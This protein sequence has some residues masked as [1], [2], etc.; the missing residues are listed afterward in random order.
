MHTPSKRY[1]LRHVTSSMHTPS[2]RFCI[3]L[4][5][6]AENASFTIYYF[7][8]FI[9]VYLIHDQTITDDVQRSVVCGIIHT[10]VCLVEV[11]RTTNGPDTWTEMHRLEVRVA[12]THICDHYDVPEFLGNATCDLCKVRVLDQH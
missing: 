6:H 1:P 8:T 7:F 3:L 12:L 2:K 11:C 9:Q 10:C 4:S 5:T